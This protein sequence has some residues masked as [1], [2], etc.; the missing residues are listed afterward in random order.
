MTVPDFI[1]KKEQQIP[2]A[3]ITSYDS[4]SAAL[5]EQSG[6]DCILVGDS[7][8][9]VMHG[10]ESTVSATMDMMEMHVAAVRRGAPESFIIGDF[11]FLAN[12]GSQDIIYDHARR[13]M[14]AGANAVKM[15]GAG[16]ILPT[17]KNLV[18]AGVPVMGHLGLTP[19]SVNQFGGYKVQ[20]RG[21]AA[22]EKLLADAAALEEAGCFAIVAECVPAE[23]GRELS[24]RLYIPVIGIGAGKDTDGQV[25]VL[26]DMLGLSPGRNPRFV[27]QYLDGSSLIAEALKRYSEDVKDRSFPD[28]SESYR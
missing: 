17:V 4:W 14:Q 23:L 8:A 19:Q 2:I 10:F 12:Q 28:D 1:S 16:S 25:L 21:E 5:I 26:H 7:G 3:M 18:E 11:P 24:S 22:H 13:L 27:R 15:E 6:I 20:G 9:M